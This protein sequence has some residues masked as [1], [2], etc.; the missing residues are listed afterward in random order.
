[1]SD[2]NRSI[3]TVDKRPFFEKALSY[4][5]QNGLIDHAK[6]QAII[7][8]GAKGSVQIAN[9]FGASHLHTDLDNARKRMVN[10]ISLFL[11][12]TCQG[13]LEKA[14]TSLR[15][16]TFLSHSRG[17]NEMLKALHALPDCAVFGDVKSQDLKSFQDERTLVKPFTLSAYR[18]ERQTRE[19]D[20]NT[21]AAA[22]WF[23]KSMALPRSALE[24]TSAET[25]IRS[26]ILVRAAG[27]DSF[28]NRNAF[29]TL[30]KTLREQATKQVTVAGK[31]KIAKKLLDDVPD[32]YRKISDKIRREIEKHDLPQI[33]N[34]AIA[35]DE[36]R[37]TVELRYFVRESGMDDVD[38]F[39]TLMSEEWRKVTNGKED[40]FSRLTAF[41]C[42][43]AET[44]AKTIIS[45]TEAKAII[46]QVRHH[47][48]NS[49]AVADFITT[50][51]PFEM[52]ENLLALWEDEF[53]PEASAY[54]LDEDDIKYIAAMKF[55]KENCNIKHKAVAAEKKKAS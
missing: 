8:D 13:N 28:P 31:L 38:E 17:G 29:S 48:F 22:T 1:M 43:A 18:K 53:L 45:E 35:L 25:V 6:C 15:D 54:L 19:E 51:A 14:A 26:A 42:I 46:R 39:D 3:A 52:K 32:E 27:A 20:A 33:A 5:A 4:G 11:E 49:E 21:L 37:N 7:S 50:A 44:K 47:G 2:N 16:N 36:L 30:L 12:E 41:L 55:L 24:F 40:P 10:L 9:F 34:S 23:A